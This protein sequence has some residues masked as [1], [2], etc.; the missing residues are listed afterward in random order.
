MTPL[1]NLDSLFLHLDTKN[2]PMHIG[3]LSIYDQSKVPEGRLRFTD[4][5]KF[6]RS[7]LG[8][9]KVFRRRLV[10]VPYSLGNPYWV[11]DPEF[12]IEFHIRHIAL[13]EPRDWRQLT[14]LAARIFA[15]PLDLTKPL[16]ELYVIEGL[17]NLEGVA[18]NSF[19]LLHKVHHSAIDGVSGAE[20]LAATHDISADFEM[21][22]SNIDDN[23]KPETLPSDLAMYVNGAIQGIKLPA[24]YSRYIREFTPRWRDAWKWFRSDQHSLT[25]AP[26][27]RFNH[28][29]SQHRVFDGVRFQLDQVKAIKNKVEGST[30]NDVIIAICGGGMNKYLAAKGESCP[31]SLLAMMPK[32]VR[33]DEA[34][35][36]EGNQI[37]I[38]RVAIGS[39]IDDP[40]ERLHFVKHTTSDAKQLLSLLGEDVVAQTLALITPAVSNLTSSALMATKVSEYLRL[41]NTVVTNVPG[42]QI[43]LYFMGCEMQEFYGMGPAV[44]GLGIFQVVFSYNGMISIGCVSC[45]QMMPDPAFYAQCLEESYIEMQKSVGLKPQKNLVSR[46]RQDRA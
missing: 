27:T 32:S 43:P 42:P 9:A 37:A 38:M 29:A 16:W 31:D 36:D 14:I 1:S 33:N 23:W 7:R 21:P 34:L 10:R 17:D 24:K 12:D 40:L 8:R 45:R 46:S 28:N 6:Y 2:T 44:S 15:R 22:P 13:P 4:I 25:N 11:E 39:H 19:A 5:L 41:F 26:A 35:N 20:L 3:S 30:L 18:E